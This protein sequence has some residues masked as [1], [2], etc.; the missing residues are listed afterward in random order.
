MRNCICLIFSGPTRTS[1][2][3]IFGRV[4]AHLR[5]FHFQAGDLHNLHFRVGEHAPADPQFSGGLMRTRGSCIFG[6]ANAHLQLFHFRAGE[7]GP[8]D[9]PFP[10]GRTRTCESSIFRRANTHLGILHFRAGEHA[11]AD[12]PFSGGP[13]RTCGSSFFLAGERTPADPPFSSQSRG[14]DPVVYPRVHIRPHPHLLTHP[15]GTGLRGIPQ[16]RHAT[17]PHDPITPTHAPSSAKGHGPTQ[18]E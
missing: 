13:T 15:H 8:A 14:G 2:S 17:S 4:K 9:P 1:R 3:S 6:R 11:P 5:I 16:A 18:R 10:G 7:R 12:P